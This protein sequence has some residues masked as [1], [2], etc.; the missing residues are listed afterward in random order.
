MSEVRTWAVQADNNNESPP[1]GFPEN[2]DFSE[3]N[4]AARE[5]MAAVARYR[6][7][8]GAVQ[9]TGSNGVYVLSLNLD[10]PSLRRGDRFI[11]TANHNSPPGGSTLNVNNVGN[12]QMVTPNGAGIPPDAM[13]VGGVYEAAYDGTRF[14]V[15]GG[16]IVGTGGIGTGDLDNGSVTNA[17][18]ADRSVNNPKLQDNAVNGR[19]LADGAVNSSAIQDQ[20]IIART[21]RD[22]NV[23]NAKIGNDAVTNRNLADR[24]VTNPILGDNAVSGRVL[25]DNAVNSS[26]IQNNAVISSK[27]RDGAVTASKLSGDVRIT[28]PNGSVG[29]AQLSTQS[30][31]LLPK[32]WAF[33]QAEDGTPALRNG[34]GVRSVDDVGIG[35]YRVNLTSSVLSSAACAVAT[36]V[37]DSRSP[38]NTRVAMITG[39]TSSS[40]LVRVVSGGNSLVDGDFMIVMF[41]D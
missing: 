32:A 26:A 20:A 38:N 27:I 33:I 13:I 15:I 4:N 5:L 10:L 39:I 7:A 36:A 16:L 18:L 14:R 24:A 25:A 11:F 30:N 1:N 22:R 8:L 29:L 41:D 34:Q 12:V 2:M 31:N 40:V 3:V 23:T 21:I 28:P 35:Q 17:K 37:R 6:E 9:T 19:V